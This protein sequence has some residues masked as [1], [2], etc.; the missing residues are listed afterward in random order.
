MSHSIPPCLVL[1]S[2]FLI[3]LIDPIHAQWGLGKNRGGSTFEE[4]QE[5][6]KKQL[7]KKDPKNPTP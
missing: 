7:G 4:L 5:V 2:L 1:L 6:A 3:V